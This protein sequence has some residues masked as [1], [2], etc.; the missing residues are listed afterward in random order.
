MITASPGDIATTSCRLLFDRRRGRRPRC[1]VT[2]QFREHDLSL[3]LQAEGAPS[4]FQPLNNK[5][6]VQEERERTSQ[7]PSSPSNS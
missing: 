7:T 5:A 1:R 6:D 4:T 3:P 2:V